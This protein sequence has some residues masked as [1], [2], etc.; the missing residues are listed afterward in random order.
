MPVV[1]RGSIAAA[2]VIVAVLGATTLLTGCSDAPAW[3]GESTE[4]VPSAPAAP[5]DAAAI[6][7]KAARRDPSTGPLFTRGGATI[8]STFT[9]NID[10]SGLQ[11]EG[12][13]LELA[14]PQ[15]YSFSGSFPESEPAK[16]MQRFLRGT[17]KI[18]CTYVSRFVV[19]VDVRSRAI[20]NVVADWA[21]TGAGCTRVSST[22][23]A[24]A[25]GSD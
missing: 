2:A 1:G 10:P 11:T 4:T 19:V 21:D 13:G 14:F 25:I 22:I 15:P 3:Q 16:G 7:E 18:R 5:P 12:V 17:M 6:A 9:T 23:P 8:S 24:E 20:V